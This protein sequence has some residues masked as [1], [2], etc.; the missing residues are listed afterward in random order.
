MPVHLLNMEYVCNEFMEVAARGDSRMGFH[1]ITWMCAENLNIC[2]LVAA[3]VTGRNAA[4]PCFV[5][6]NALEPEHHIRTQH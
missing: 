1:S 2:I 4:I 5:N 3:A 6:S